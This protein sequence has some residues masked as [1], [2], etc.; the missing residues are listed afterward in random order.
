MERRNLASC[1]LRET[2]TLDPGGS[3]MSSRPSTLT[4]AVL[5]SPVER[6]IRVSWG[7]TNPSRRPVWAAT[8]W[9][10]IMSASGKKIGPPADS[11]YPVL[12]VGRG[13]HERVRPVR[14]QEFAVHYGIYVQQM[15]DAL[16]PYH[17]VVQRVHAERFVAV[18]V[19]DHSAEHHAT[20]DANVAVQVVRE[21]FPGFLHP[22]FAHEAHATHVHGDDRD[23]VGG[24]GVD[25]AQDGA[26]SPG[27]DDQGRV[28]E[29]V[30]AL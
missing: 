22:E 17:H 1:G 23:G 6:T 29:P 20:L 5:S 19:G 26:I 7:R 18:R 27:Y 8:G 2:L 4:S 16:A 28:G 25:G 14:G 10:I 15:R 24:N 13:H 12:P 11:A 30:L 21:A 9:S 3:A